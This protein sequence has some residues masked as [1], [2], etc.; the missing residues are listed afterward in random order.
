MSK[1]RLFFSLPPM[2][3]SYYISID[4]IS[5]HKYHKYKYI[6]FILHLTTTRSFSVSIIF[7]INI[8]S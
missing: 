4:K 5:D 7:N 2:F 1:I 8:F 3:L 6:I